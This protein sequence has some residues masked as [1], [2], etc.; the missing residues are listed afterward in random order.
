MRARYA[1]I[2]EQGH[3]LVSDIV[4][5]D[6]AACVLYHHERV[7][8]DGYPF[9]IGLRTLAHHRADRPGGRRIRRHDVRS[10]I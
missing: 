10:S 5:F 6:V 2:P 8:A 7:D 9:G 3:R 4:P 1:A